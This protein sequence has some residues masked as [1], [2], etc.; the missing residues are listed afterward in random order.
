MLCC[1][2]KSKPYRFI[3]RR[4]ESVKAEDK[5][6]AASPPLLIP[7]Q[8]ELGHKKKAGKVL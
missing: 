2:A 3:I 4:S 5:T 1:A 8:D 6:S 7:W